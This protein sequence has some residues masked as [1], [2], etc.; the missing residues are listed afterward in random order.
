MLC[1]RVSDLTTVENAVRRR[2]ASAIHPALATPR[3]ITYNGIISAIWNAGA[4]GVRGG[5]ALHDV[6]G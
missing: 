5:C 1:A 2:P 3:P 4:F 6:F